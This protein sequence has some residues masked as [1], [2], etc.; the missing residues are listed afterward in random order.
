LSVLLLLAIVLSVLPR[1]T[2]SRYFFD[3]VKH[4]VCLVWHCTWV[5]GWE[6]FANRRKNRKLTIFNKIH[7]KYICLLYLFNCLPPV[8]SDVNKYNLRNNQNYVPPR[9][10]L[11]TSASSFIPST[12]LLWNNL[13]ISIRNYPT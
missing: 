12:V 1:F 13:D 7:N 2:A 10:R 5:P 3:I 4:F 9:C 6:T 11:R 8:T